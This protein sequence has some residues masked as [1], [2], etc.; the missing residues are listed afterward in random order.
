MDAREVTGEREFAVRFDHGEEWIAETESFA[1]AADVESG[2]FSATGAVVDAEI[3]YYDQDD[4]AYETVTYDEPLEVAVCTG[5]IALDDD[6]DVAVD[7]HAVL[8]RPSGQTVSGALVRATVFDAELYC[9]TFEDALTRERDTAS[10]REL[11]E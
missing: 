9:R 5:T 8:S 1:T 2:W 11:W 10:G 3:A 4:F 6:G 7:A